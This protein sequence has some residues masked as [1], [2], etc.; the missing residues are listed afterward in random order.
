MKKICFF[1]FLSQKD[2]LLILII[3]KYL[4]DCALQMR[5]EEIPMGQKQSNQ[6]KV[7]FS[8]RLQLLIPVIICTFLM[9]ALIGQIT[10]SIAKE[11]IMEVATDQAKTM[12]LV[13]A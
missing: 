3:I 2:C 7:K 10:I 9:G 5:Q 8:I 13:A 1:G 11:R 6:K 12:A 4:H